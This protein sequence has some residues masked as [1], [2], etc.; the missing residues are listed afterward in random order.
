MVQAFLEGRKTMTRRIVKPQPVHA[1]HHVYKG[2]IIY[3]GEH[4]IWCF[5]DMIF[6]NLIDF[7]GGEDL[8]RLALQCPYGKV[9]DILWVRETFLE[10]GFKGNY[11]YKADGILPLTDK[12]K[13]K[14][15]IFMPRAACRIVLEIT[16]IRVERLQSISK[17]DAIN[18]GI[19]P[20][21]TGD[22]LY[23]NYAKVG[24]RWI[25]AKESYQSLWESINGPGSWEANPWVWVIEFTAHK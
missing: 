5:K 20:E 1:Q 16:G 13:W 21:V 23:E 3:E 25:K 22:D 7:P 14:P 17:C 24:Y 9:G 10:S 11:V 2:K 18:E 15:S 12:E 6:E 8:T 19:T 4:R